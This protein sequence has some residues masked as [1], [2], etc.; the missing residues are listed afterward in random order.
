MRNAQSFAIPVEFTWRVDKGGYRWIDSSGKRYLCPAEALDRFDWP[1]PY[2]I[3]QRTYSPLTERTGLFREFAGLKLT[4]SA[5]RDFANQYGQLDAANIQVHTNFGERFVRGETLDD[6]SNEIAEIK[7][8]ITLWDLV[9]ARNEHALV[10]LTS[11]LREEQRPIALERRLHLQDADPAM[12]A[13]AILRSQCDLR[14]SR[15]VISRLL[16]EGNLPRLKI[17][18]EPQGLVAALWLQFAIAIDNLKRYEKCAQCGTAFEVSRD[19]IT[20]KRPDAQFCS[21]RCRV[22]RY[23]G[24]IESARRMCAAGSSAR[25]IARELKTQIRTV[26]GWLAH[27]KSRRRVP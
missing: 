10:A 3:G 6:W 25:E 5:I 7:L 15:K 9:A 26:K 1:D 13:L 18:L 21:P 8:A 14:L 17:S 20:G 23:R 11:K 27:G 4:E 12:T 24:R 2:G 16:F 19:P 22:N